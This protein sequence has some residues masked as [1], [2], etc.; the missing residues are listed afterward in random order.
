MGLLKF[1][2]EMERWCG[3]REQTLVHQKTSV[4]LQVNPGASLTACVCFSI[5]TG[6]EFFFHLML[7]FIFINKS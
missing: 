1:M 2:E 7:I 3:L 4:G 5:L 6:D